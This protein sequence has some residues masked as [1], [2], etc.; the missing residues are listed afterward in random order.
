MSDVAI[1]IQSCFAIYLD[2]FFPV[3][4][5]NPISTLLISSE[6]SARYIL[7]SLCE[8]Y[9]DSS[10]DPLFWYYR[11]QSRKL[12]SLQHHLQR[13]HPSSSFLFQRHDLQLEAEM[14]ALPTCVLR[15]HLQFPYLELGGRWG[16]NPPLIVIGASR[17]GQWTCGSGVLAYC[18]M[19]SMAASSLTVH[20]QVPL[21]STVQT[22]PSRSTLWEW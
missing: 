20:M 11:P 10:Q 16:S 3:S 15:V 6:L 9:P 2:F 4:D 13:T 1:S 7:P 14:K 8:V 5:K 17:R 12:T 21:K 18:H 19:P 22:L